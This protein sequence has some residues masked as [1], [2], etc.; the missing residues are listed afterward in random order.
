MR[1]RLGVHSR[2]YRCG[3][4]PPYQPP[5]ASIEADVEPAQPTHQQDI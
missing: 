4:P 2:E 5:V 1:K 3:R